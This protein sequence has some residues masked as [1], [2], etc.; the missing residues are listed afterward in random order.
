MQ[1][2]VAA[3]IFDNSLWNY[4]YTMQFIRKATNIQYDR[5]EDK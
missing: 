5:G 1:F 2:P 3:E 4:A